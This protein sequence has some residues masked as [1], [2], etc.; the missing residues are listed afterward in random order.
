MDILLLWDIEFLES[1][2]ASRSFVS[3]VCQEFSVA[4]VF[5]GVSTESRVQMLSGT[6]MANMVSGS[7]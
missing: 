5:I 6:M 4:A 3:M 1:G 2:F 7:S